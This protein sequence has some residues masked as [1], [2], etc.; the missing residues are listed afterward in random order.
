MGTALDA[1]GVELEEV[2]VEAF[3]GDTFIGIAKIRARDVVS[4]VDGRPSD[5]FALAV[6]TGMPIYAVEE[7]IDWTGVEIPLETS[8]AL[9]SEAEITNICKL[10][11][12]MINAMQKTSEQ[13]SEA[14]VTHSVEELSDRMKNMARNIIG[15]VFGGSA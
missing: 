12:D 10:T 5:V 15:Q 2:Q 13:R 4:E 11:E 8:P 6:R 14:V 1:A 3:A 7:V 9:K